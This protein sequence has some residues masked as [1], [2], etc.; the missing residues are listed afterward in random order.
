[1][2]EQELGKNLWTL[3]YPKLKTWKYKINTKSSWIFKKIQLQIMYK[4]M[5]S[6]SLIKV[7]AVR[8]SNFCNLFW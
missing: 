3:S 4:N 1:M 5:Y 7:K 8:D 6:H 2:D